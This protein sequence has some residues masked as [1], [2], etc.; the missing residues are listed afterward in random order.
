MISNMAFQ[1][2]MLVVAVG[3]FS[4]SGM[5]IVM[6]NGQSLPAVICANGNSSCT[7]FPAFGP[8]VDRKDCKAA[9]VVYP[10]TEKELVAAVAEAVKAGQKLKVI[11]KLSHSVPKLVCPDGD[12]GLLIS[13]SEYNGITVDKEQRTATLGAG[14]KLKTFFNTIAKDGLAFPHSPYWAGLTISGVIS[15]GAHG[16]SIYHK[17]SAVHEYVVG[18][19]I[20]V[21][22]PAS[23]GYAKVITLTEKDEDLKAARVSMGLLGVIS[24][25]TLELQPQFKRSLTFVQKSDDT[26]EKEIVE[27]ALKYEFGDVAWHPAAHMAL[28]REDFRVPISTPGNGTNN[29]TSFGFLPIETTVQ[30][31]LLEEFFEATRNESG[32]CIAGSAQSQI[33]IS[34]AFGYTNNG[35]S[36][37]GYPIVGYQ[38]DMET[39]GTCDEAPFLNGTGFACT[40]DRRINGTQ[41]FDMDLHIPFRHIG[42]FI[43]DVK[44]LVALRPTSLCGAELYNGILMRYMKRSVGAHLGVTE[45]GVAM[46]IVSY[47]SRDPK[48][49]TLNGDTYDEIEQMALFKY[50]ARAHL[51]KNRPVGFIDS[52]KRFRNLNKFLEVKNRYD[53]LGHFS[54][55]WTDKVLNIGGANGR[56]QTLR[57]FCALE[58]LCICSEDIHCNPEAFY[59]CRSGLVFKKARVCRF[60]KPELPDVAHY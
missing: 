50:K 20:V 34:I 26:L 19:R 24:T 17:G 48:V 12:E 10:T 43:R 53:P 55:E 14:V 28:Y 29:S 6:T 2:W 18:M 25:V 11:S 9:R 59:F 41:A 46:D 21:A 56:I 39:F 58:G 23:E 44:E 16:S 54:N 7:I 5:L 27:N 49:P 35:S 36:F 60:E 8:W 32:K 13:T 45:D 15:T 51:G 33:F 31:R 42:D 37:T 30:A 38:N 1:R 22:C 4:W 57:P 47:R 40:W 52:H 3:L